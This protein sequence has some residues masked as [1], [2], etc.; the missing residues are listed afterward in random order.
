ML[1]EKIPI[2]SSL[3]GNFDFMGVP[4][5]ILTYITGITIILYF[6][7][8][9]FWIILVTGILIAIAKFITKKDPYFL[10]ILLKSLYKPDVIGE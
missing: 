1:V 6:I 4:L 10:D 5:S 2:Y 9:T 3:M 7:T 8:G